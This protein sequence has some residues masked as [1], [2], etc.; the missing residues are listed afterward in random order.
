VAWIDT[1]RM[2]VPDS[3]VVALGALGLVATQ[4]FD[5]D[6]LVARLIAAAATFAALCVLRELFFRLRGREGFGLGDVKFMTASG[7]VIGAEGL[8][9]MILLASLTGLVAAMVL[10]KLRGRLSRLPF[11][12]HLGAALWIADAGSFS[13]CRC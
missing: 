9:S 12:P 13:F 4:L 1:R 6:S 7:L 3:L 2:I 8:P 11:A 5:P 10:L